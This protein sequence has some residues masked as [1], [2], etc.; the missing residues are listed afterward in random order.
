MVVFSPLSLYTTYLGWQYYNILFNALWQTGLLYLGFLMV[1][2]RFLKH[3]LAPTA[4]AHHAAEYALNNFLY[5]LTITFLICAFFVY[6]CV[7]LEAQALN[8]KPLC[9]MTKNT[10]EI[11]ASTLKNSGTTY[12]EAFADLLTT[13]VKMPIGF[14][15]LQNYFSSLTYGLMKVTGCTDS[16]Q[17]IEGDLVSIYLP[18]A[19]RESALNFH[20]QC[21]L[22][23]RNRY[24]SEAH[25]KEQV[26]KLLKDYGGE[27][28]LN[29]MGS[30]VYQTLYYDNLHA[31]SPVT[32]FN[33]TEAPN[34]NLKDASDRGDIEAK[35][36]PNEGY[37]TCNAWWTKLRHDLVS[38]ANNASLFDEH[39]NYYAVLDR[40]RTFKE[41]HPKAWDSQL[42]SEDYVAKM[43]LND[44][45]DLQTHSMRNLMDNTNSAVS[46]ALSHGL[47]NLGQWAKSWTSTPLKR[48]AIM[49]TLP[50]MQAFLYF[51]LIILTPLIL[52]LSGY[53][54]KALGS[55]CGLFM[56]T[57]FLQ[58]L[59]H[60]VGFVERSVLDPL[61]NN[62]VV[63]A[64]RNMAVMFYF[65][66][67]MVL[68]RLSYHFGG[69][70]GAGLINL[71]DEAGQ[72]SDQLA[73]SGITVLNQGAKIA[74]KGN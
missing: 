47:V 14:A 66:A 1:A 58:Y 50:V 7:P 15:L 23:A 16:L 51:F 45:K 22:E 30:K 21:F 60:L 53:S 27:D 70:A 13:K 41:N 42:S 29:W 54:P 35:H 17:A 57:I 18:M 6:P 38:I 68:L 8:F 52:S 44:N 26:D 48:E 5:E 72:Q 32:G 65:I 55:L 34:N 25:D 62:D 12:D 20:R 37:P 24:G 74:R 28:D 39:L 10:G 73:H 31:R 19:V 56:M 3:A 40:V 63:A 61:G 49:Q 64:M 36:L 4:S 43:L 59:W 69:E 33:F 71:I 67:P 2:Y 9:E 46:G 11:K